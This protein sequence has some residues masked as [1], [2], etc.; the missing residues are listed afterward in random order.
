MSPRP[1]PTVGEST[2]FLGRVSLN[3]GGVL[4][5]HN[6]LGLTGLKYT[7]NE[8]HLSSSG[9]LFLGSEKVGRR[10][11]IGPSNNKLLMEG[12]NLK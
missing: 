10:A 6:M 12:R 3:Y 11:L 8:K 1:Q 7:F 2:A 4:R 9:F 5:Q